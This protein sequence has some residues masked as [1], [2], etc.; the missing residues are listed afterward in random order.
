M[1]NALVT[2]EK[3]LPLISPAVEEVQAIETALAALPPQA[4]RKLTDYAVAFGIPQGTPLYG[5]LA[6]IQG[7]EDATKTP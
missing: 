2:L 4:S 5:L 6:L 7:I 1:A 3:V